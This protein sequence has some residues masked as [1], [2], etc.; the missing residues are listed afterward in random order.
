M[1][2]MCHTSP[3]PPPCIM[4]MH[5]HAM[6]SPYHTL[7][8]PCTP[9]PHHAPLPDATP[10]AN[11]MPLAM[12]AYPPGLLKSS[13]DHWTLRLLKLFTLGTK[14]LVAGEQY[15]D[16]GTTVPHCKRCKNPRMIFVTYPLTLN[17]NVLWRTRCEHTHVYKK[18]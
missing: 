8:L 6:H 2:C 10:P 1:V 13:G 4:A 7:P 16:N 15:L 11:I 17:V 5:S 12:H 3:P 14:P 9:Q 18:Q